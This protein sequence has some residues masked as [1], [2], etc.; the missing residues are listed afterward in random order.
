MDCKAK[1][2]GRDGKEVA[3]VA[4]AGH[5]GWIRILPEE[6]NRQRRRRGRPLEGISAWS[7]EG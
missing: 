6:K 1:G 3:M 5:L 4:S 2:K 7:E